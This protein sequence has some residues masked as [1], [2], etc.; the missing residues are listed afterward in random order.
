MAT[1]MLFGPP[2]NKRPFLFGSFGPNKS[3]NTNT[4]TI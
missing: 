4:A 1:L 2:P 3:P